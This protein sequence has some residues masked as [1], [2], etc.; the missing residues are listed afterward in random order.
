MDNI[1][2]KELVC[3]NQRTDIAMRNPAKDVRDLVR[4]RNSKPTI[5]RT[6]NHLRRPAEQSDC[7]RNKCRQAK[8]HQVQALEIWM[9]GSAKAIIGGPWPEGS[10]RN[11]GDDAHYKIYCSN[12]QCGKGQ[13]ALGKLPGDAQ[14]AEEIKTQH[15]HAAH[16]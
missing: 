10:E 4:K 6:T 5:N 8:D 16:G 2:L 13:F 7:A 9:H 3:R 12:A 15:G 1:L 11:F 14:C